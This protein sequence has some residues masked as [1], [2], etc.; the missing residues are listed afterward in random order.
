MGSKRRLSCKLCG[1]PIQDIDHASS[2]KDR[3]EFCCTG[4]SMVFS[5]LMES[6]QFSDAEDYKQTELYKNCVAAGVIPDTSKNTD[7][8]T[9]TESSPNSAG[10][11]NSPE[12]TTANPDHYLSWSFSV[13]NMW[14]PACAWVVENTLSR[15]DGVVNA[16]CNFSNDRGKVLYD[17]VKTSPEVVAKTIS[18]LGYG[19]A[20]L[21]KA[22]NRETG[23]FVRLFI[24]LLCTM[25]IMMISW[26]IYTGFFLALSALSVQML[27]WPILIMATIV[28]LYGGY[29]IHKRALTGIRSGLPGMET[30]ISIGSISAY[31]YSLFHMFEGNIHLYFDA[32]SMLIMLILIGK[33]LE[34][35]A[36]RKIQSGLADFFSLIP[37]K[38]K[39]CTPQF[40]RGRYASMQQLS[41]SDIFQVAYGEILA[42]DGVVIKGEAVIDES[43]ITGEAKPLNATVHDKVRSGS[44]VLSGLIQV[45]ALQVGAESVLGKMMSIMENSLS[46]KTRQT[47][48]L[49]GWL[50]LFVPAIMGLSVLTFLYGLLSGL[51]SYEALNRGLSVMVISCPCALGIAIP[52]ALV[53][54]VS[55]AGKAGILVRDFE[56]FE[57]IDGLDCVVFDKTGTLTTGRM[58]LLEV[59]TYEN[60]SKEHI[61]GLASGMETESSHFI[62]STIKAYNLEQG[63]DPLPVEDI[64]QHANGIEAIYEGQNLRLGSGE[65]VGLEGNPSTGLS[66]SDIKGTQVVSE[67]FLT[68]DDTLVATMTFGDSMRKGVSDLIAELRTQQSVY[69]ISGDSLNSTQSAARSAGIDAE[70]CFGRMLPHEKAEFI[71]GLRPSKKIIAMVGDGVNDAPAM[72]ASDMAVAV[73]SGLNP[74]EG[75]A[76]ITLMQEDPRQLL[77]FI[78]LAKRV[79]RKVNQN[80]MFAFIYNLIG[81]PIAASGLLNPIIAATAMLFSSLSVT[82][83]TLFLV[84]KELADL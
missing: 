51:S 60:K 12:N 27:S 46:G 52:L 10:L 67:I 72:A 24:T 29:P 3:T 65:F 53:A 63:L 78:L 56:A 79:N 32:S 43:S 41:K 2:A 69:L 40:P 70:A 68:V 59:Q 6:D 77:D 37:E 23:E 48:R 62:A 82:I 84:K 19:A 71:K 83:N 26:A 18:R 9:L 45:Q 66:E 5:M 38:V 39:I 55:I 16:S 25:N 34:Q 28:L 33:R 57:K 75:V 11:S 21:E 50:K 1:L 35:S 15:S 61:L 7:R 54:G 44:Q 8:R 4:C 30:L 49:E 20:S 81:I 74:G 13:T 22:H 47:A 17:P 31:M 42:A 64:H 14:C 73:H 76:A 58:Q 36:K 80:L